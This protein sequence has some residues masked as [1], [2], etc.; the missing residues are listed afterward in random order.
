[1]RNLASEHA[2]NRV[3]VEDAGP[4]TSLVQELLGEVDGIL[5]VKPDRDKISRLSVVSARF[6]SGLVF[7][8]ERA[9]WPADFETELF[10]FP[11]SRHDDQCDSVSQA[12]ADDNCGLPMV[13]SPEAL[14][15]SRIRR[16][17]MR[18]YNDLYL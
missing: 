8:L 7:L 12:L 16:P 2:A 4:G 3:L 17:W 6:E 10:A 11:A 14:A 13:I 9:S 5:A 15:A 1:V 18:R